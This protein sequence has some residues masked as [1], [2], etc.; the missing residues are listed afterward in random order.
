VRLFFA[1]AIPPE[2]QA[3]LGRIRA[4]EGGD[5]RWVE[6]S[7][8]HVTLAFLGEQPQAR[9]ADLQAIGAAAASAS[10]GGVLKLGEPGSFGARSAPRVL[11]IGLAGNLA[12]LHDLQTRLA[13]GLRQAGLAHE[14]EQHP[15]RAHITLARRRATARSGKLDGWPPTHAPDPNTFAMRQLTLFESRLSPRGAVYTSVFEFPL[16]TTG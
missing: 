13:A 7:S 11:W 5:Y 8:L 10:H 16:V 6:P 1:I 2:V 15:F 12:A 3:A 14:Q 9:L 4:S